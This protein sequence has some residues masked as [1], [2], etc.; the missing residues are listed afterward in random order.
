VTNHQTRP[1]AGWV[2][3][4]NGQFGPY[5]PPTPTPRVRA[6]MKLSAGI[7]VRGQHSGVYDA[8]GPRWQLMRDE[9]Q[10]V[11]TFGEFSSG[12]ATLSWPTRDGGEVEFTSTDD[13][14]R[15][16]RA[17]S[18]QVARWQRFGAG[19]DEKE[20]SAEVDVE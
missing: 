9:A 17:L 10:H 6:R 11:A 15:V 4:G 3:K 7:T 2:R 18:R 5:E 20:P 14:M 16:V 12:E 19:D 8:A 13:F 1:E